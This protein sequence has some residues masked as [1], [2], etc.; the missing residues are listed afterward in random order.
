MSKLRGIFIGFIAV[1][2]FTWQ[3]GEKRKE[4]NKKLIRKKWRT[5]NLVCLTSMWNCTPFEGIIVG[6][7]C[8]QDQLGSIWKELDIYILFIL[9]D[10]LLQS[11]NPNNCSPKVSLTYVKYL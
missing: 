3:K 11:S 9:H 8:I 2:V 6:C 1:I 4:E 10:I 7:D 5:E